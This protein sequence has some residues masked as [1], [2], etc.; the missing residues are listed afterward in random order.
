[1]ALPPTSEYRG[2][3]ASIPQPANHK[4]IRKVEHCTR[5]LTSY[6]KQGPSIVYRNPIDDQDIVEAVYRWD[7]SPYAE[8]FRKGFL[9]DGRGST[10]LDN[11]YNLERHVNGGG[12]PIGNV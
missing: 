7:V 3:A 2:V 11:Y 8:V 10:S 1:M 5:A 6:N 9:P 12:A 4:D